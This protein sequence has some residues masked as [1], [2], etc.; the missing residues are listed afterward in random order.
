MYSTRRSD[1]MEENS[2]IYSVILLAV[3]LLLLLGFSGVASAAWANT[4]FDMCMNITIIN[5]SATSM[6]NFPAFINLTKDANMLPDYSDL[7]F[8]SQPCNNGGALLAHEVENY[9]AS[10]AI[11]WVGI[12]TLNAA[13]T[14][15]SVYYKN[16]TPV[17]SAA[18]PTAVWNSNYVGVWHMQSTNPLDSTSNGNNGTGTGV[19][20][21]ATGKIDGALNFAGTASSYVNCSNR[22]SLHTDNNLTIQAWVNSGATKV[23]YGKIAYKS[24]TSAG[25]PF[26]EYGLGLDST[27]T[28]Y[29]FEL[30]TGGAQ[31]ILGGTTTAGTG[32]WEYVVGVY[33]GSTMMIYVNGTL[34]NSVAKT[35]TINNYGQSLIIGSNGMNLPQSW[36]GTLDEV[37]VSNT[38]LSAQWINQSFQ[39]TNNNPAWVKFGIAQPRSVVNCAVITSS[40]TML[41]NFTGAP[42]SVSPP[43]LACID[44]ESS[45]LVFDCNGYSIHNNGTAGYT[46]GIYVNGSLTNVT[47]RNC[48]GVFGYYGG[49]YTNNL[50]YG[51]VSNNVV[52][53]NTDSCIYAGSGTNYTGNTVSNCT[54]GFYEQG[55]FG[56][57]FTGNSAYNNNKSGFYL[58][59]SW[60][61]TLAN[62]V[63][64]NN[65]NE[66]FYLNSVTITSLT[67][68]T[69]YNNSQYGFHLLN[70]S[71]N[72]LANDNSR[73]GIAGFYLDS[74]SNS[75]NLAN[76]TTFNN[77]NL[78]FILSSNS[79]NNLTNDV[80]YNN[81]G[82]GSGMGF[83]LDNSTNDILTNDTSNSNNYYGFLFQSGSN[84]NILTNCNAYN[85]AVYGFWLNSNLNNETL[86]GN[87]AFN[88]SNGFYI[89]SSTNNTLTGNNANN[90]QN[91]FY[92]STGSNNTLI[93][94]TAFNNSINGIVLQSSSNT[95]IGNTAYNSPT[96]IRLASCSNDILTN[97]TAYNSGSGIYLLSNSNN[98][99]LTHNLAFN[100][101]IGFYISPSSNNTFTNNTA[102]NDSEGFWLDS[103]SNNNT[104]NG[105]TAYNSISSGIF[106]RNA[107]GSVFRDTTLY[108]NAN[109]VYVDGSTDAFAYRMTNTTFLNPSG[110]LANHTSLSINDSVAS[111]ETYAINWSN[112]PAAL[113]GSMLSFAQKFVSITPLAGTPSISSI[114]W[115]WQASEITGDP[116]HFQ[117]WKYNASGWTNMNANLDTV[118]NTLTLSNVVPASVYGILQ[119]PNCLIVNSSYTMSYNFYGAPFNVSPLASAECVVINASNLVFD[120]NGYSI[121]DTGTVNS[122]GILLNGSITNV[123]VKNCHVS[124]YSYSGYYLHNVN[125]S[126]FTDDIVEN[127]TSHNDGFDLDGSSFNNFTRINSTNSPYDFYMWTGA[128]N[129]TVINSWLIGG[130]NT[131]DVADVTGSGNV[132]RNITAYSLND[133]S[134]DALFWVFA[135]Y[136][137]TFDGIKLLYTTADGFGFVSSSADNVIENSNI[138]GSAYGVSFRPGTLRNTIINSALSGNLLGGVYFNSASGTLSGNTI[139]GNSGKGVYDFNSTATMSGDR[140]FNNGQDLNVT[141][142]SFGQSFNATAVIFD[143]PSGNWQYYTNLSLT[144]I[145]FGGAY[146]ISWSPAPSLP[147]N[148][149]SFAQKFVNITESGNPFL[150]SSMT[151]HWSA[152]DAIGYNPPQ[153]SLWQYNGT[154][155]EMNSSPDTVANA[156]ADLI[157]VVP[158][159]YA[160]L[161]NGTYTPPVVQQPSGGGG[162]ALKHFTITATEVCPGNKIDVYAYT[163][164]GALSGANVREVLSNPYEGLITQAPTDSTGHVTFVAGTEGSYTFSSTKLGYANPSEVG[165]A[166]TFCPGEAPPKGN[167]TPPQPPPKPPGANV[168]PPTN[169]TQPPTNPAIG[170]AQAAI[171]AAQSAISDAKAAGKDASGASDML[172]QAQAAFNSGNYAQAL[173]LA[174]KAKQLALSAAAPVAPPK[175]PVK[176]TPTPTPAVTPPANPCPLSLILIGAVILIAIAA[177]AYMLFGQKKGKK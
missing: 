16:N 9:T 93:G 106:L 17:S 147:A 67:N 161:Y 80:T 35:G 23:N 82:P 45:N 144:D 88:S 66:G 120:C 51:N 92:I 73:S 19:T 65:S 86:I 130:L 142:P 115:S 83:L 148:Y 108:K 74:N 139:S 103:A 105:N 62:N 132:F 101:N 6:T 94:N 174:N 24:F 56:D 5:S 117:L 156:L 11:I 113:P 29:M 168:T 119:L 79:Y 136:N 128:N 162:A 49:I 87:T 38:A 2:R 164:S 158:G 20:L 39:M 84:N 33:N 1:E 21:N 169:K 41:N 160:I 55:Q 96:G 157:P 28:S 97:N 36:N 98:N 43:A 61:G 77:T 122:I 124:S 133:T 31:T 64:Y 27:H 13:N 177:G 149:S 8:F 47:I 34:Q 112:Q 145:P 159:V 52:Y 46:Y 25:A 111:G 26:T 32:V 37:E 44:I 165:V 172:A 76:D 53:N 116:S 10:Y 70:S 59:S 137:N 150:I 114:V 140:F 171:T 109:D 4:S 125:S 81:S 131:D 12:P 72:T 69:A 22:S 175:P 75:N 58:S 134:S 71:N 129:N 170:Q 123:T 151:W 50:V 104:L 127:I 78:G 141:L 126:I 146:G 173:D 85:N 100:S 60:S 110:T 121:T 138:N 176:V 30:T 68:N 166:F 3:P 18:N 95:L 42:N 15:I 54:Y 118:A 153:F 154:W 152:A 63:A 102:Y 155:S 99:T 107:T 135:A 90:S 91:G 14:T 143:N 89:T 163:T 57:K 48:A 7:R 167:V 40:Y